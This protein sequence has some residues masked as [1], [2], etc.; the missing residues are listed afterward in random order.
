MLEKYALTSLESEPG[1]NKK[2]ICTN[3]V[4]HISASGSPAALIVSYLGGAGG[5]RAA[6]FMTGSGAWVA[7]VWT[8]R[9]AGLLAAAF[10]QTLA[11]VTDPSAAVLFTRQCFITRQAAGNVLQMARDVASLLW[12]KIKVYLK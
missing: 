8:R 11:P 5:V 2:T 4:T 12:E 10:C 7:A 1:Y 3:F 6:A 9:G